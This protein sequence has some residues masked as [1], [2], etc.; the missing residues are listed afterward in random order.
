MSVDEATSCPRRVPMRSAP[1]GITA[2][3]TTV[4]APNSAIRLAESGPDQPRST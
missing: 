4:T 3:P 1:S 2:V